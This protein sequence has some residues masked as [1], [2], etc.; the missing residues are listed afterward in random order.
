MFRGRQK[1]LTDVCKR[2]SAA[3]VTPGSTEPSMTT[4][5]VGDHPAVDGA[6]R[7]LY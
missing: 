1:G 4:I 2:R 6:D 7:A 3:W 5:G